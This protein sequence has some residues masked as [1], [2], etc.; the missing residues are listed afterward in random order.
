MTKKSYCPV[1]QSLNIIGDKWSLLIIRDI[2][3]NRKNHFND[4]LSSEEKIPKST[5]SNRLKK[6]IKDGIIMKV[7]DQTHKQKNKYLLT[8]KGIELVPIIAELYL[9][10]GSIDDVNLSLNDNRLVRM[11][12]DNKTSFLK[13]V[14]TSLIKEV[15]KALEENPE[16]IKQ[17]KE[18][19]LLY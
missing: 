3:Y 6:L 2:I 4:F 14:E 9:F 1:Y 5:L 19:H 10:S 16:L 15:E 18:K 7:P 17:N 13:L 8:L 12:I 11:L